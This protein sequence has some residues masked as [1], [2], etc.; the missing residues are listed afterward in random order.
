[1]NPDKTR[2]LDPAEWNFERWAKLVEERLGYDA[3][4]YCY[5]YE[6]S[7]EL[8][9]LVEVLS[10]WRKG[11]ESDFG[12]LL[13]CCRPVSHL[14]FVRNLF[15]FP[16]WPSSPIQKLDLSVLRQRFDKLSFP[17]PLR[18]GPEPLKG[19]ENEMATFLDPETTIYKPF[20]TVT[21][22]I[23]AECSHQELRACFAA[24]LKVHFPD[25]GKKHRGARAPARQIKTYL[26]YLGAYRLLKQMGAE[27]AAKYTEGVLATELQPKPPYPLFQFPSEWS[28]ARTK[29][30]ERIKVFEKAAH[31]F[32]DRRLTSGDTWRMLQ[33]WAVLQRRSI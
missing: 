20:K 27:Q 8:T 13:E 25:Q 21:I 22:A 7:R 9:F 3:L 1:V 11:L 18:K 23:P 4:V 19:K 2:A 16:E 17:D 33:S 14:G 24:Y 32:V 15:C 6:F 30:A 5:D 31:D 28:R 26:K 29:A 12:F 10:H